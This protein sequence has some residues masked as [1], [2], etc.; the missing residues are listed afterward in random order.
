MA[1]VEDEEDRLSPRPSPLGLDVV[2]SA[3]LY[4]NADSLLPVALHGH[5]NPSQ[6]TSGGCPGILGHSDFLSFLEPLVG[7]PMHMLQVTD[8]LGRE[9]VVDDLRQYTHAVLL[10]RV[11][12]ST[13]ANIYWIQD[14]LRRGELSL[15]CF[16]QE[17]GWTLD[18]STG[19]A[20]HANALVW[21]ISHAGLAF[22]ALLRHCLRSPRRAQLLRPLLRTWTAGVQAPPAAIGSA[23]YVVA[24]IT[25]ELKELLRGILE[26]INAT[27]PRWL[28]DAMWYGTAPWSP[29]PLCTI[30]ATHMLWRGHYQYVGWLLSLGADACVLR[31]RASLRQ[32][33]SGPTRRFC[34]GMRLL[35]WGCAGGARLARS[36]FTGRMGAVFS[37]DEPVLHRD[38]QPFPAVGVQCLPH[39]D[40]FTNEPNGIIVSGN[41][42]LVICNPMENASVLERQAHLRDSLLYD[43]PASLE[44]A[45]QAAGG[46]TTCWV[47]GSTLFPVVWALDQPGVVLTRI[48]EVAPLR[49]LPSGWLRS[50]IEEAA[51]RGD[52]LQVATLVR[53]LRAHPPLDVEAD[54]AVPDPGH[55]S[56]IPAVKAGSAA[57]VYEILAAGYPTEGP[58]LTRALLAAVESTAPLE[59]LRLLLIARADPGFTR[60]GDEGDATP[61]GLAIF[62]RMWDT[63]R[64]LLCNSIAHKPVT[65]F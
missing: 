15:V 65:M 43:D 11:A 23:S 14:K 59:T 5:A 35:T 21:S 30:L 20:P 60:R 64:L 24:C 34:P 63:V 2:R 36:T 4:L 58:L 46:F 42:Q 38:L 28:V 31:H 29:P 33:A 48:L 19:W 32:P 56:L 53:H 9:I 49:Q 10:P 37:V 3:G 55:L 51:Q 12:P 26:D 54:D 44:R 6:N 39:G 41:Y 25:A 7:V 22:P 8:T 18:G 27:A 61:F 16:A 45:P 40:G 62:N 47:W 1:S 52:T 50:G 17:Q 13:R 57:A